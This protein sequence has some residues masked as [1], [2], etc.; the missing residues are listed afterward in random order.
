M[1]V[2]EFLAWDHPGPFRY[3]LVDGEPR[4][5]PLG[6]ASHG[7]LHSELGAL[8][9]N[10]LDAHDPTCFVL[11]SAGIVPGHRPHD[12]FRVVDL[13]VTRG[14]IRPDAFAVPEPLLLAEILAPDDVERTWANVWAYTSIAS[15]QEILILRSDRI[16][17]E[18]LRRL[19]SGGWPER[20]TVIVGGSLEL[21]SIGFTVALS[22]LYGRTGLI[23]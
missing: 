7:L 2:Q 20:P 17:A 6:P 5:I 12:N 22:E 19:P 23:R 11:S 15:V 14:P 16:A 3:E 8:L 18:L 4:A 21:G 13:A 1:T 9:G 10:H